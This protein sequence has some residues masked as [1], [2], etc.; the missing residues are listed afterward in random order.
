MITP[1]QVLA[2]AA[3]DMND[4]AQSVYT[5]ATLLPYF[6]M[7]VFELFQKLQENSLPITI[8]TTSNDLNCPAGIT[9]IPFKS[10]TQPEPL[11]PPDLMEPI[12]IWESND[13]GVTWTP[14]TKVDQIDPNIARNQ[15]ISNFAIYEWRGDRIVVPESTNDILLSIDYLRRIVTVPMVIEQIDKPILTDAILFLAHK[16]AALAALLVAQDPERA[17][18]LSTLAND[19]L[20]SEINIPTKNEQ[21]IAVR[22]RPFRGAF[23]SA[24]RSW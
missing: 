7:A 14:M 9:E 22:R 8:K 20:E 13:D 18:A 19:T 10:T 24:R 17:G 5:E 4:T 15:N 21:N 16:T 1:K 23:K 6:N 3:S 2:L 12:E 11:L